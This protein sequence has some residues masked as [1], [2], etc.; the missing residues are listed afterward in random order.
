MLLFAFERGEARINPLGVCYEANS[1]NGDGERQDEQDDG[2][3]CFGYHTDSLHDMRTMET[4]FY[5]HRI[6]AIQKMIYISY[7]I[8]EIYLSQFAQYSH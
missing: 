1:Q 3:R 8:I 6:R 5:R 4:G 2:Q 7:F